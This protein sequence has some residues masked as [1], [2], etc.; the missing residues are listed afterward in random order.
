[1]HKDNDHRLIT[2][3][4]NEKREEEEEKKKRLGFVV[5]VSLLQCWFAGE[6]NLL[7]EKKTKRQR[8]CG[9]FFCRLVLAAD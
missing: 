6:T 4:V 9:S 7:K 5:M 3:V 2:T 1:M 8:P